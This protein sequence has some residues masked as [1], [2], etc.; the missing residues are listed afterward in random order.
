MSATWTVRDSTGQLLPDFVCRSR[1]E[2]C[3]KVV[4][5][6]YD[7]FRLEVSPS[8]REVFDRA[9]AQAL[10]QQGWQ[11]VRTKTARL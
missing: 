6:H 8:Y 1:V 5:S 10:L 11:I 2:V 3:R 7:A 4:P 9:V